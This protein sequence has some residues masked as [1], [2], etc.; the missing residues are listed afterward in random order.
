MRTV[1]LKVR[2]ENGNSYG[3]P[4]SDYTHQLS[5]VRAAIDHYED[6][7]KGKVSEQMNADTITLAEIE[8]RVILWR[9]ENLII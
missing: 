6:V 8:E 1:L 9:D 7:K 4:F 2:Y 5:S 3:C